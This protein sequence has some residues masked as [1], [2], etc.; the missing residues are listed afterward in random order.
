[1]AYSG[2]LLGEVERSIQVAEQW[3]GHNSLEG[4]WRIPVV[5]DCLGSTS[6]S[7]L[8]VEGKRQQKTIQYLLDRR[9]WE[10]S[11][12]ATSIL[13]RT[14]MSLGEKSLA[15]KVG[16]ACVRAHKLAGRSISDADVLDRVLRRGFPET[17]HSLKER[18]AKALLKELMINTSPQFWT[19]RTSQ[20]YEFL[21]S[22]ASMFIEDRKETDRI[23]ELLVSAQNDDGSYGGTTIN[24][25]KAAYLLRALGEESYS[26][27]ALKW[28]DN[29]YNENGSLRPIFCQDVYDT[30]W[31]VI[32]L[33]DSEGVD[34]SI[35]WLE[36]TI[37]EGLGYPY[38]SGGY[39]PDCDD[40]SLVLLARKEAGY[41]MEDK[42]VDFLLKSQ[43]PDGG[44]GWISFYS[45]KRTLPYRFLASRIKLIQDEIRKRRRMLYWRSDFDSTVDITSRVLITLAN[46][47]RDNEEKKKAVSKGV[48]Y[49]MR[50]YKDGMFHHHLRWTSS[51]VYETSMAFIA[52]SL[53]N[54]GSAVERDVL[55]WLL[56]RRELSGEELAHLIWA[57]SVAD[58]PRE[59]LIPIVQRLV[60]MQR[61]DGSWPSAISFK[62]SSRFFDPLFSTALP[63]LALKMI[64]RSSSSEFEA[65]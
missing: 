53:N 50:S 64:S 24:T 33:S 12:S 52:L 9:V 4:R 48:N 49:L 15:L 2:A 8:V 36:E 63:L 41:P 55:D 47:T 30:A 43:N 56:T 45:L 14:L 59:T 3:V 6:F 29:V 16:R 27:R 61:D 39:Y 44:W 19:G 35:S 51:D 21:P 32:A 65:E 34:R 26:Q 20:L 40:T 42:M 10:Q 7:L 38:Y 22:I 17:T 37:V 62:A 1:M 54:V 28:L 46:V 31:A 23:I 13:V 60:S 25:I 58:V 5:S 57:C 18:V 11:V